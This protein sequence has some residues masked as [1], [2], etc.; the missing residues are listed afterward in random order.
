MSTD[1]ANMTF[2]TT[3]RAPNILTQV[4]QGHLTST[5]GIIITTYD[6]VGRASS[7]VSLFSSKCSIHIKNAK[8]VLGLR[9]FTASRCFVEGRFHP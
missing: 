9:K 4:R 2:L 3:P 5:I 6:F 7:S 8:A 1:A